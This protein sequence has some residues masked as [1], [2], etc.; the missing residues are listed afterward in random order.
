MRNENIHNPDLIRLIRQK[1]NLSRRETVR[2][3]SIARSG[4]YG[5]SFSCAEIMAA[6]YYGFLRIRPDQPDWPDRDRFVL[7]K[8]HAAVGLYPILADLGFFPAELLDTYTRLGSPFGDHPDMRKIKGVDFSSGSL[9]HGLSI[10]V[11][12]ALAKRLDKS[13][14]RIVCLMGDGELD[15]GQIWEAAMSAAHYKLDR[16]IGIV[17]RND[18]SVDG[19]TEQVMALEPLADKWRAFGWNVTEI[20]GHDIPA[21]LGSLGQANERRDNR[22]SVIIARTVAGK[23]VSFMEDK[24]EWHLGYLAEPDETQAMRELAQT[25]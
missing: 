11:G 25:E 17:D 19:P 12:M 9:G 3:I 7:S 6:L 16:L 13:D 15:E 18:V 10:S 23:G 24:Y 8:G 2:L 21:I 5:T 14:G 20:D 4:H 22:P 1:A